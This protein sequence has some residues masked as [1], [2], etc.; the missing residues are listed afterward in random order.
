M[1]KKFWGELKN[2]Q[3]LNVTITTNLFDFFPTQYKIQ[4]SIP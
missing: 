3:L 1:G 2:N 4:A